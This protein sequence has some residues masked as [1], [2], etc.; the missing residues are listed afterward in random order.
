M[1]FLI[2]MNII[3][4]LWLPYVIIF[5]DDSVSISVTATSSYD[6]KNVKQALF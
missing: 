2:K 1:V 5:T 6:E 4:D 3:G